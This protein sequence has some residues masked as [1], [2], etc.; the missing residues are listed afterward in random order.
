MRTHEMTE[1]RVMTKDGPSVILQGN[2][3]G[4]HDADVSD[5][6]CS[7]ANL[8]VYDSR[9][10]LGILV[11]MLLLILAS[12]LLHGNMTSRWGESKDVVAAANALQSIPRS[13]GPWEQTGTRELTE[14]EKT[15]L[16]CSSYVSRL[17]RNRESGDQIRLT[18]LMGPPDRMAAHTP[19]ICYSTRE[20]QLRDTRRRVVLKT[21][22]SAENS[23]WRV[24]FNATTL[25]GGILCVYYAWGTGDRWRA[26]DDARFAFPGQQYLFKLQVSAQS[27]VDIRSA[28]SDACQ[29]FLSYFALVTE[30]VLQR[31]SQCH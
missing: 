5:R 18:L 3:S 13:V 30:T 16:H 27:P 28:S 26:P 20:F 23:F 8:R 11:V 6:F 15:I 31:R 14:A 12:G 25:E 7:A 22:T 1:R 2:A 10:P 21:S 29:D 17:Y 24:T 19:E 9:V 4:H